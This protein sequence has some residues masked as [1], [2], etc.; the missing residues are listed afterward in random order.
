M[1]ILRAPV[2]HDLGDFC[3]YLQANSI[4]AY[5]FEREG[6]QCLCVPA[7]ADPLHVQ[8]LIER[9]NRGEV[10]R[11]SLAAGDDE[12]EVMPTVF[13]Q[14]W[15]F[16]LTLVLCLLSIL[17]FLA[18]AT[19]W[20]EP[21][22][23]M[24]W[25]YALSFQTF[26]AVGDNLMMLQPLPPLD[27]L[28]RFWT[29]VLLHFSAVHVFSNC[30]MLLEFGRRVESVQGSWRLLFL[31]MA[32]GLLSNLTQFYVEPAS[33]FG[34]MSG[35]VFA[36]LGYCW[37]Y[38]RLRPDAGIEAPPGLILIALLWLVIGMSGV[39]EYADV[40]GRI[41]NAAHAGGLVAGLVCALLLA[42]LDKTPPGS[43]LQA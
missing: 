6:M 7:E 41:A 18:M 19:R 38:R 8:Q 26:R 14:W 23:G 35:V 40:G 36:L 17:T 27:E 12:S 31:V 4:G 30:L 29:P 28:W 24:A 33:P 37:L 2:D 1:E 9:W 11:E 42:K 32:C 43:G 3:R 5:V 22:G 39:V 20:G 25:F 10:D 15:R 13:S 16:P 34:G 21:L